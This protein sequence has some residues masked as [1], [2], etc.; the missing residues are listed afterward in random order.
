[1]VEP[2]SAPE[3]APQPAAELTPEP[4]AEHDPEPVSAP[5]PAPEQQPAAQAGLE[6]SSSASGEASEDQWTDDD[7]YSARRAAGFR[8]RGTSLG[9]GAR[10]MTV[11]YCDNEYGSCAVSPFVGI[12]TEVGGRRVRLLF[13]LYSAPAPLIDYDY[14]IFNVLTASVGVAAGNESYRASLLAGGGYFWYGAELRGLFAPWR[15][16]HGGRH[17]IEVA[18]G[19][20]TF[21]G[22]LT[23]S[24]RWFPAKLNL[25][26]QR[27]KVMQ[28]RA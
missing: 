21:V 22:T 15:G 7:E 5:A 24:Y 28:P 17:G 8:Y 27:K 14:L 26:G 10:F 18:I 2:A 20:G 23:A 3:S 12:T 4:V 11:F 1:M 19:W 16:K 6:A 9:F 13:D 25:R